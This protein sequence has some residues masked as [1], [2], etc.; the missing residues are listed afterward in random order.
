MPDK[1][2]KF[3]NR[4]TAQ[5]SRTI[6]VIRTDNGTEFVNKRVCELLSARGM[7][8]QTSVAYNPEQNGSAERDI[9]TVI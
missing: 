1:I 2:E 8:P 5:T 4:V 3:L 7:V 9:R 6:R